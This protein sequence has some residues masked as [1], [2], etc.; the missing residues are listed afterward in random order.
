MT[1]IAATYCITDQRGNVLGRNVL[2]NVVEMSGYHNVHL[3]YAGRCLG[4]N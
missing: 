1:V 3:Q 2:G 4:L